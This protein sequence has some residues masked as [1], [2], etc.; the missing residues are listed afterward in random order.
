MDFAFPNVGA[1]QASPVGI[2]PG[3]APGFVRL[4]ESTICRLGLGHIPDTYTLIARQA[5]PAK[6]RAG[7]VPTF[8]IS[9]EQHEQLAGYSAQLAALLATLHHSPPV[10]FAPAGLN[11]SETIWATGELRIHNGNEVLLDA[12]EGFDKKLQAFQRTRDA[13]YFLAPREN[14]DRVHPAVYSKAGLTVERLSIFASRV[15]SPANGRDRRRVVVQLDGDD[16]EQLAYLFLSTPAQSRA[17]K[18]APR[19]ARGLLRRRSKQSSRTMSDAPE[20][21][22]TP[23][24]VEPLPVESLSGCSAAVQGG[25]D[26]A[27]TIAQPPTMVGTNG[28]AHT[29]ASQQRQAKG[30]SALSPNTDPAS[31]ISNDGAANRVRPGERSPIAPAGPKTGESA[32]RSPALGQSLPAD[33]ALSRQ[34][35]NAELATRSAPAPA[36]NEGRRTEVSAAPI[37]KKPL[38]P[39][40]TNSVANAVPWRTPLKSSSKECIQ[41]NATPQRSEKVSDAASEALNRAQKASG[42]TGHGTGFQRTLASDQARPSPKNVEAKPYGDAEEQIRDLFKQVARSSNVTQ[43][44]QMLLTIAEHFESDLGDQVRALDAA[45]AAF[46]LDFSD[47][48]VANLVERRATSASRWKETMSRLEHLIHGSESRDAA[49]CVR[50]GLWYEEHLKRPDLALASYRL[51]AEPEEQY[52]TAQLLIAHLLEE[53]REWKSAGIALAKALK[54]AKT[55]VVR[56]DV[57]MRLGKNFERRA[58]VSEARRFY[59]R[60][61]QADPADLAARA[62][63]AQLAVSA[64]HAG[65]DARTKDQTAASD[66]TVNSQQLD[67]GVVE[68]VFGGNAHIA[69]TLL[70]E[71]RKKISPTEGRTGGTGS[72]PSI[73]TRA[74]DIGRNV[75]GAHHFAG[76]ANPFSPPFTRPAQNPFA[77]ANPF[78]APLGDSRYESTA[79]SS[80]GS[81]RGQ[82]NAALLELH[83]CTERAANAYQRACTRNPF[84]KSTKRIAALK[85]AWSLIGAW[86]RE[87]L[88]SKIVDTRFARLAT[89]CERWRAADGPHGTDYRWDWNR[90]VE[91]GELQK[92]ESLT[93][94]ANIVVEAMSLV[95]SLRSEETSLG[96]QE[97]PSAH[98]P[99]NYYAPIGSS[100]EQFRIFGE[101]VDLLI[102][103][104]VSDAE[105]ARK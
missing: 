12:V 50:A 73:S 104:S 45:L 64:K 21:G 84:V 16:I 20:S 27:S 67:S 17:A 98:A 57:L 93:W 94:F 40:R 90:A 9:I 75:A 92:S 66:D 30:V 39:Q 63:L 56:Q 7:S 31:Q 101:S 42:T 6:W 79:T 72:F 44:K 3:A 26:R 80:T 19:L 95:L 1:A 8:S 18:R 74:A 99:S 52:P 81:V 32:D 91:I 29:P 87:T 82:Q 86:V 35:R 41:T 105:Q 43:K 22:T 78:A 28:S 62:A 77:D 61:V 100:F 83:R 69:A 11:M 15:A 37:P 46:E 33:S 103:H 70:N 51:V 48:Q 54:H 76:A 2:I 14:V 71:A 53:Q 55:R 47:S 60:A 85:E 68:K 24:V 65:T 58:L 4:S 25:A 89:L 38:L 88:L 34:A 13:R 10:P 96:S 59:E 102:R 36:A 97:E 49:L 5:I 23:P